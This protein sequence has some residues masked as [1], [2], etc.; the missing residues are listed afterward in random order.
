MVVFYAILS[1]KNDPYE[2]G[3]GGKVEDMRHTENV[4]H[5]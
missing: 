3:S 1:V 4:A 5:I 2:L